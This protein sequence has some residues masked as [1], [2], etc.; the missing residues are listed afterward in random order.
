MASPTPRGE[1]WP[2]NLPCCHGPRDGC[3]A[4]NPNE[5]P[6]FWNPS[7]PSPIKPVTDGFLK[8]LFTTKAKHDNTQP[9]LSPVITSLL[10]QTPS[11]LDPLPLIHTS[12]PY[13]LS[14]YHLHELTHGGGRPPTPTLQALTC[15][16]TTT[17]ASSSP[18]L[19][20]RV[21]PL[22]TPTSTLLAHTYTLPVSLPLGAA[23]TLADTSTY[24]HQKLPLL[25]PIRNTY[26][27]R[28]CPHATMQLRTLTLKVS[29]GVASVRVK[30]GLRTGLGQEIREEW[31]SEVARQ[32]GEGMA[33]GM[34]FTDFGVGFELARKVLVTVRVW[35]DLGFVGVGGA[36]GEKW[37]ALRGGR[38]VRR[39]EGDFGRV[40]RV[41]EE[42]LGG[43]VV[44][45]EGKDGGGVGQHEA[46]GKDGEVEQEV[47]TL[48]AG[49]VV[50]DGGRPP[51]PY[52]P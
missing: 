19:T 18:R 8:S 48:D 16:G 40:R 47:E 24:S 12:V 10:P 37:E 51:P 2:G 35:K 46:M 14:L 3:A 22:S 13:T 43:D 26:A 17:T 29:K 11:T 32:P 6:I 44:T 31:R 34:C 25:S 36:A 49:Q 33:C 21:A 20:W 1:P 50:V 5:D 4:H 52:T 38:A 42:V 15:H 30:Y 7:L 45:G 27:F 28:V 41:Y 9:E 39:E 23:S